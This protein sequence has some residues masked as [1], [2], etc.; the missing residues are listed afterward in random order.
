MKLIL[1]LPLLLTIGVSGCANWSGKP[2]K[3]IVGENYE[4]ELIVRSGVF[5]NC[6]HFDN[7]EV[8]AEMAPL[9]AVFAAS[10]VQKVSG[11]A[12]DKFSEALSE[13]AKNRNDSFPLN[14]NTADYLL[15]VESG[16]ASIQR[17]LVIVAGTKES[18][19][20]PCEDTATA[21]YKD[22]MPG[23]CTPNNSIIKKLKTWGIS[24]PSLYAEIILYP[25]DED[26]PNYVLPKL[27]YVY[28]PK[29]LSSHSASKLKSTIVS[30]DAK[31]PA[32][33]SV[34]SVTYDK[35]QISPG[36]SITLDSTPE[37]L[38]SAADSG[39][40]TVIPSSLESQ[41]SGAINL[42]AAVIETPNP[43]L[44]IAEAD[45]LVKE[46]TPD[47]KALANAEMSY[48]LFSETRSTVRNTEL[49]QLET[50]DNA[51]L[52]S[53]AT[54]VSKIKTAEESNLKVLENK[55]KTDVK[56]G[57]ESAC[58]ELRAAKRLASLA[59][60]KS[61]YKRE[62]LCMIHPGSESVQTGCSK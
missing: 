50:D 51:A 25:P 9:A 60:Q 35:G 36:V 58:V 40:W 6:I 62:S 42:V 52:A 43:N 11:F 24:V 20:N 13:V 2:N 31:T 46:K 14:G 44:L 41:G 1:V 49:A 23:I 15:R 38:S 8:G 47:L 34:F 7:S 55:D 3:E 10:A 27:V 5:K 29:P 32:N 28:Y 12:V 16:E 56:L 22:L 30:I 39:R 4:K 54:F 21:W 26:V 17:C 37:N 59:W 33:N 18:N 19:P 61:S 48:A 53:C 57:H 45:S